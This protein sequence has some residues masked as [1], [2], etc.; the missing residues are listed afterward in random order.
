MLSRIYDRAVKKTAVKGSLTM[1]RNIIALVLCLAAAL[2]L[3]GC[4]SAETAKPAEEEIVGADPSTWG[5][6]EHETLEAAEAAADIEMTVPDDILGS[7]P[8]VFLTWYER[9]YIDAVYTDADGNNTA[10]VRKAAGSD[11]I[12][13]DYNDYTEV[14]TETIGGNTVTVKGEDGRIMVATWTD[15]EYS[16]CISADAGLTVDE[17][18][19]LIAEVK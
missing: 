17:L 11:D 10:R 9:A 18:A 14:N 3:V 16:Y 2:A 6:E 8:T 1:R 13:G 15:G 4:G 7:K 5:P 19:A 12:S